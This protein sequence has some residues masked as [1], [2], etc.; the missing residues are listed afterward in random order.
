M[1]TPSELERQLEKRRKEIFSDRLS[2]SIG[3]IEG[4]YDRQELDIHPKFQRVLRWTGEQKTKLIESVL[5]RIPLPPLFVAQDP[6]G[7]WDVVDGVQRIGTILEFLG[8]LKD[9]E[10]RTLAPLELGSTKLLPALDGRTFE[11]KAKPELALTV[12]QR[13]DFRRSR[14][15]LNIILKESDVSARYELFERLNTGGSLAS[16]QEVRNCVLVWID[17]TFFDWM[18]SLTQVA[19]FQECVQLTERL[20]AEQYRAELLLRFLALRTADDS[21]LK[22]MRDL[23]EFLNDENRRLPTDKTFKRQ[24]AEKVFRKTFE[25]L[26]HALGADSFRRYDAGRKEFRG[27]FLVS[28]FEAVA[29]GVAHNVQAWQKTANPSEKLAAS[30][31]KMW[32]QK[33]FTDHIGT[34]A[35]GTNRIKYSV[36]FGRS[37]FAP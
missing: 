20:E 28:A 1:A 5:L 17:E 19:D 12:A 3:E 21:V 32:A 10:N 29:C 23:G 34:G 13:L 15:D 7:K 4:L 18:S 16:P 37:F 14:L 22:P 26:S 11:N 25:L 33:A 6:D 2:M 31:R 35:T 30:I 8:V 24:E 9:K 36:P 27:S